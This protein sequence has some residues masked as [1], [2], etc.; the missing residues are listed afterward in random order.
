VFDPER[1]RLLVFGTGEDLP[2]LSTGAVWGLTLG[3]APEWTL[4]APQGTAPPARYGAAAAMD[5]AHDRVAFFAGARDVSGSTNLRDHW[6]LEFSSEIPTAT[7]VSLASS[8][9][10][11]EHVTLTWR[12][13]R[14]LGDARVERCSDAE[15]WRIVG[16]AE[17]EGEGYVGWLD[18]GVEPGRRYG[19]RLLWREGSQEHSS[20]ESWVEVPG[21]PELTLFAPAPNP[22]SGDVE[23]TFELPDAAHAELAVFDL[24]GRRIDSYEVGALGAGRHTLRVGR[25]RPLPTGLYFVRLTRGGRVASRRLFVVR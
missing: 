19:Y 13:S 15:T 20:A 25:E 9:A 21:R 14:A 1:R 18:A 23:L 16:A 3:G 10:T 8:N 7:Q 5:V 11:S 6:L 12:C 17:S 2:D 22:S 4:L 24:G